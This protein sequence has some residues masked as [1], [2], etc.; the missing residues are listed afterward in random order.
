MDDRTFIRRTLIVIALLALV[1]LFWQL[2]TLLLMLFGAVVVATIFRALAERIAKLTRLPMGVS[3][4]L[5]VVLVLGSIG[6]IAA[7]FGAQI[8]E[9]AKTLSRTLPAAWTMFE[10]RLGDMGLGE[11][12]K[13]MVGSAKTSGGG[14]FSGIGKMVMSLGSGLAD[15][16]V[17]IFGGIFL[18]AQPHF[19][20]VGATK[21]VPE[22]KR[23][24]VS[25]AMDDSERALR[26]W[27][28][29]QLIAMLVVGTLTGFGLWMLGVPSALV[30]GLIAG[31][32][33]FVPF[34]GPVI[35]AIPAILLALAVSPDL[36][37]WVLILYVVVQ[38]LE[39][40]VLQ[41]LVQQYAVELPGV[42]LLFALI[43]FGMLFGT[44]GIIVAAPLTVVTYVL[45]KKLYVREA[46]GTETPIPGEDKAEQDALGHEAGKQEG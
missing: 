23:E 5:S 36:A 34:A 14:A 41:P 7:L 44:L 22:R 21:L 33:E 16:L 18:A 27:L 6:L 32:L 42:I 10:A 15:T 29:G 9:Q 19:Y 35:A 11:Q 39:G 20:K 37:L 13:E 4:G 46:L 28:K 3:V 12:L 8:G 40:Y 30:L 1:F 31:L 38:Q 17:V 25:D 2:R 24:L 43:G 26:L 45:V